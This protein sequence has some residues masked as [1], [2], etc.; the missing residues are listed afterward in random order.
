MFFFFYLKK[1]GITAKRTAFFP[2]TVITLLGINTC[3][4]DSFVLIFLNKLGIFF[5]F[6]YLI[7]HCLYEDKCWDL[8]KY[9][10]SILNIICTSFL[11]LFRPFTDFALFLKD[12]RKVQ[13]KPEGKGKYVFFGLIIAVPLFAATT[14]IY[15]K[16][17]LPKL[18]QHFE[19]IES[20]YS[21]K[22]YLLIFGIYIVATLVV[23]LIMISGFLRKT[24]R[25]AKEEK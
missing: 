10:C 16:F 6:F 22:L 12:K 1:S 3:I 20:A 19:Y 18:G 13:D 14:L 23:L 15:D 2:V 11:Y 9:L 7:I 8:S 4:T 24:I 5:L 17:V 25:E 21:I